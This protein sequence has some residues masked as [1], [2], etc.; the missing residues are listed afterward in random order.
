MLKLPKNI[1]LLMISASLVSC[2]NDGRVLPGER[3]SV[4]PAFSD[5]SVDEEASNEDV[6]SDTQP[7]NSDATHAGGN[8]RHSGGNLSLV[9][10]L[11]LS[12]SARTKG[13]KDNA[14]DLPQPIIASGRIFS[15]D[16]DSKL[17]A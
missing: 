15:I 17:H 6:L 9:F 2:A 3:Q 16:G 11:S 4:L 14:I 8:E 1:L 13:I 12:W 5:V 7:I 10:P